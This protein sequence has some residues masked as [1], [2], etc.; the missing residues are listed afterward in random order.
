MLP[1]GMPRTC[2]QTLAYITK[3]LKTKKAGCKFANQ[4]SFFTPLKQATRRG[5]SLSIVAK[6]A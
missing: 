5:D 4:P 1:S 6:D 3:R 2:R